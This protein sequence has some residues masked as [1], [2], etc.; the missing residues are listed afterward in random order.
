MKDE[1]IQEINALLDKC[2][3]L[4]ILDLICQLLQKHSAQT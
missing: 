3:D 1:Y 4:S 2:N